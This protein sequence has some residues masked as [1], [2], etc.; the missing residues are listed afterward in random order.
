[1]NSRS[2]YNKKLRRYVIS[3]VVPAIITDPDLQNTYSIIRICGIDRRTSPVRFQIT[4]S[5]VNAE[6]FSMEIE[7]ALAAGYLRH[8]NIFVLDNAANHSGKKIL[9]SRSGCGNDTMFL[10]H[11]FRRGRLS[12]TQLSL[13]GLVWKL[14][15]EFTN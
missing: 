1:M 10:F 13:S 12:G 2:I 11:F 5:T 3:S 15:C 7:A 14:G 4:Q 9:C 8:G 6:L